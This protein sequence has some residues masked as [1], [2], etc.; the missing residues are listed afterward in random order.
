[1]DHPDLAE[2][3]DLDDELLALVADGA[4]VVPHVEQRL[5]RR[6][7]VVADDRDDRRCVL[8]VECSQRFRPVTESLPRLIDDQKCFEKLD[9]RHG[10]QCRTEHQR[11]HPIAERSRLHP[12]LDRHV[13]AQLGVRARDAPIAA[14]LPRLPWYSCHSGM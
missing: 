10:W 3:R 9:L 12:K 6:G 13:I 7:I 14:K 4:D 1:M 8:R 11:C 5:I 2:Q